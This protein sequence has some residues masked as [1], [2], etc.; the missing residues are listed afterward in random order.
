MLR[1]Q[2]KQADKKEISLEEWVESERLKLPR[3]L[4][5]LTFELFEAWKAKWLEKMARDKEDKIKAELAEKRH[6]KK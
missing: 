4:T 6:D 3:D 2:V 1:D 5:P